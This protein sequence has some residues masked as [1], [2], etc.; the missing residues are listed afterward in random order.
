MIATANPSTLIKI[1]H[2][3]N[4][5]TEQLIDDISLMDS[6][7]AQQLQFVISKT[8]QLRFCDVWP[9]LKVITTW[10]G[11]NCGVLIPQL[12]NTVSSK[13]R[14]VELGYIA[15]EFRGGITVDIIGNKQIPT[16]HENFYEFV[17][18]EN[19]ESGVQRFLRLS[20]IEQGKQYYIFATTGNGLY[21]YHINDLI[22]VTGKLNNTPTIEFVQK[23]RGVL[24]LTGEKLYESQLVEAMTDVV[25]ADQM[26][27][28]FFKM[29][30]N[31]EQC[32]YTL[33]AEHD[34]I[35]IGDIEH[36]LSQ[37]NIEF[38]AKRRSGRLKP[39][40]LQLV[41]KGT[42]EAYK[43]FCIENGQRESQFK[44]NYLEDAADC[45]FDF[46]DYRR[47]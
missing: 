11:G 46:N 37:L 20:E 31:A 24:N 34:R 33:F 10:T 30:G 4:S 27:I 40:K 44:M 18:K 38:A 15:S 23:G 43:Q 13:T 3:M 47:V 17:E 12:K 29:L 26:N 35:D 45:Q 41:K 8:K 1:N 25:K 32:Q 22:R 7:R 21:R 39:I 36:R 9:D 2:V 28:P 14:F 6:E 42:G 5:L 19:W 16:L